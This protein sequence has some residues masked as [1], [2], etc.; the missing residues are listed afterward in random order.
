MC[1]V[2][3]PEPFSPISQPE[4]VLNKVLVFVWRIFLFI[5]IPTS[6]ASIV[7]PENLCDSLSQLAVEKAV[8]I[9][10]WTIVQGIQQTTIIPFLRFPAS[11]ES[12]TELFV[13]LLIN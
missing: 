13:F 3:P 12:L 11:L 7:F 8:H 6:T 5:F 10:K 4:R 1:H 9:I 2:V